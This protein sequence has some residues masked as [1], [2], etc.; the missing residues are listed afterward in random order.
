MEALLEALLSETLLPSDLFQRFARSL[1]VHLRG[2]EPVSAPK[3]SVDSIKYLYELRDSSKIEDFLEHHQDLIPVLVDAATKIRQ[4]D[5]FP[6]AKLALEFLVDPEDD[7]DNTSVAGQVI[8]VIA[9]DLTP[10]EAFNRHRRLQDS[11]WLDV[12]VRYG[13]RLGL[14]LEFV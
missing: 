14:D 5:F 9:T 4:A 11:W 6:T 3:L 2:A 8:I 12:F 10:E 13:D 1:T 7:E